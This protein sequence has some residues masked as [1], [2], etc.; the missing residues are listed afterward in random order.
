MNMPLHDYYLNIFRKIQGESPT[1]A[2][3]ESLQD[4]QKISSQNYDKI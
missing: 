3:Y 2:K 4:C 1:F